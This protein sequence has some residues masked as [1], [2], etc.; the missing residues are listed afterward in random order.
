MP[1][2]SVVTTNEVTLEQ[3]FRTGGDFAVTG[4]IFNCH[5]WKRQGCCWH[6]M[7]RG[8]GFCKISYNGHPSTTKHRPIQCT[9]CSRVRTSLSLGCT[10]MHLTLH[11]SVQV[12]PG[13][14]RTLSMVAIA[15]RGVFLALYLLDDGRAA[16][17]NPL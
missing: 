14:L 7:R 4:D 1:W 15:I 5:N 11:P 6:L 3:R 12:L 13:Y 10:S 16:V 2:D 8:Q 17:S 9:N